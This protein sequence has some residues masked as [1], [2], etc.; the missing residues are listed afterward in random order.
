MEELSTSERS[1]PT[2]SSMSTTMPTLE[3]SL[4]LLYTEDGRKMKE[5]S[6]S[7]SR[8]LD[9]TEIFE[10]FSQSGLMTTNAGQTCRAPLVTTLWLVLLL[11]LPTL[12]DVMV[13]LPEV[14]P[15]RNISLPMFSRP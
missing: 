7:R 11:L 2:P 14:F 12:L 8:R 3:Q 4:P 15:C 9:E 6:D 5:L 13:V 10:V 1:G